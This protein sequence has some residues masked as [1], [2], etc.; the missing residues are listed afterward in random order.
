MSDP[1]TSVER[2]LR[3][4]IKGDVEFDLI[5]RRLYAT[6][7]GLSQIEPLG[8]VSPRD[9]DDVVRLVGYAAERVFPWFP[10]DGFGVERG[11]RRR[12]GIQVDFAT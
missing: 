12:Y 1:A 2:D 11:R 8:V 3:R 9:A 4:M 10:W 5:S 7:A 6:D